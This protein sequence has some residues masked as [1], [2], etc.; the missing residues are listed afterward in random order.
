MTLRKFCLRFLHYWL[1]HRLSTAT[2]DFSLRREAETLPAGSD[3]PT[4]T[5]LLRAVLRCALGRRR[6]P[7][8]KLATHRHADVVRGVRSFERTSI[9]GSAVYKVG[10][11]HAC[12][13]IVRLAARL[14]KSLA[15]PPAKLLLSSNTHTDSACPEAACAPA[16][17]NTACVCLRAES[18]IPAPAC[19]T[20]AI[21]DASCFGGS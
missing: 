11:T 20:A 18:R 13:S 6:K 17:T 3:M 9:S 8:Y 19:G 12:A 14:L 2:A 4:S 21:R 16:V 10:S 1:Q 15:T 5:Y 7:R